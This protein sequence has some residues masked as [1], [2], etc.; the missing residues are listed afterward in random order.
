MLF[1]EQLTSARTEASLVW[2]N[3]KRET[4]AIH[5]YFVLRGSQPNEVITGAELQSRKGGVAKGV[6]LPMQRDDVTFTPG[7]VVVE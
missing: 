2:K 1:I 7:K 6:G 5:Q 4:E 3:E